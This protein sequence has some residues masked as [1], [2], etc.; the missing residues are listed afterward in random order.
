M[1]LDPLDMVFMGGDATRDGDSVAA[2]LRNP[3]YANF[4]NIAAGDRYRIE[5][6]STLEYIPSMNF[7]EWSVP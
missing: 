6:V 2:L 1:P 3:I 4:D 7:V 5:I